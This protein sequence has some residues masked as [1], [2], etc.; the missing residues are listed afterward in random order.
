[1]F[2][3]LGQLLA[4]IIIIKTLNL[5]K[6]DLGL[7][8]NSSKMMIHIITILALVLIVIFMKYLIDGVLSVNEI[9]FNVIFYVLFYTLVALTKELYFRGIIYK[10][11]NYYSIN[12]ALVGS[13]IIFGLFHIRAGLFVVFIMTVTGLSFAIVRYVSNMILLLIPFHVFFNFQS[14]LFVFKE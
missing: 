12:V 13:S 2:I 11:L 9:S 10:F 7:T 4:T 3:T 14:A 6:E 8:Y 1:M 5:I